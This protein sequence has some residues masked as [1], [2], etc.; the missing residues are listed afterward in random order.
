MIKKCLICGNEFETIEHGEARKYCFECSPSY[1]KGDNVGRANTITAI[2]HALKNELIKRKGGACEKCGY[3]R[4]YASLEF[5]H[6]NPEE[7][8]F[9][10][11]EY[12]SGNNVRV[13]LALEEIKKCALLCANCHR[14]F[15][16]LNTK[17]NITYEEFLNAQ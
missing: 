7:K 6:L 12:C 17:E 16:D 9:T 15:H 2:R 4:C 5:H 14:E 3:N 8:E 1:K 11:S 10:I 13:E